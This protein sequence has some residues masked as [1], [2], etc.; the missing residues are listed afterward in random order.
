M[1]LDS[2]KKYALRTI[3]S[4]LLLQGILAVSSFVIS[5]LVLLLY[6]SAVN[7]LINS[8]TQFLTYVALVEMGVGDATIPLLYYPLA[9]DNYVQ[10]NQIISGA[11]VKYLHAGGLYLLLSIGFSFLYAGLVNDEITYQFAF[12][13]AMVITFA[14]SIDYLFIGKY[15][16]LLVASQKYYIL[17]VFK[18]LSTLLTLIMSIIML[19]GGFPLLLVKFTVVLIRLVEANG[20]A[21]YVKNRYKWVDYK[22]QDKLMKIPQQGNTLIRNVMNVIIYNTDLVVLTVFLKQSLKEVSVYTVYAMPFSLLTNTLVAFTNGILSYIGNM[23]VKNEKSHLKSF[24]NEFEFWYYMIMF[25]LFTCYIILAVPFVSCYTKDISDVNYQRV[26]VAILFGMSGILCQMHDPMIVAISAFGK[27]KETQS[28]ILAEATVNLLLSVVLVRRWGIQGVLLGTCVGH[29]VGNVGIIFY[30]NTKILD[31]GNQN[32]VFRILRN[33]I[34]TIII[35]I[36][37][38]PWFLSIDVW[39]KWIVSAVICLFVNTLI[40]MSFNM[41]FEKKIFQR[42][43]KSIVNTIRCLGRA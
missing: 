17:N 22:S 40:F 6:G 31:R 1:A 18:L 41:V 13:M 25:V 19:I 4:H 7:G 28:Y 5:K 12:F 32:T 11:R 3:S 39:N 33:L 9:A 10:V 16:I 38:L 15:K 30:T 36:V 35:I 37:E 2:G 26:G 24:M 14:Y 8:V 21:V 27:F 42:S 34:I 20:I 43:I 29:V 23:R